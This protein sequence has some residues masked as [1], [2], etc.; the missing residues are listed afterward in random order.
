MNTD[1]GEDSWFKCLR[2]E[3][4]FVRNMTDNVAK[5]ANS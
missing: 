2:M 4:K 1:V 3:F 5:W